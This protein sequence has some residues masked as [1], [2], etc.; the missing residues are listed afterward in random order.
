MSIPRAPK[1]CES[2]TNGLDTHIKVALQCERCFT[3]IS[4][5]PNDRMNNVM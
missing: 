5:T 3:F 4:R 2:E 1:R